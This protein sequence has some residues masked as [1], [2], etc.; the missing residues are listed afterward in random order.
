MTRQ[1][2]H[3]T[4]KSGKIWK[5]NLRKMPP[6]RG[7]SGNSVSPRAKLI[8]SQNLV[9]RR[10]KIGRNSYPGILKIHHGKNRVFYSPE[11]VGPWKKIQLCVYGPIMTGVKQC[12]NFYAP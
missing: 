12:H 6:I 8:V 9:T 5:W 2:P 1:G 10:R 11:I 7:K 4:W 3:F